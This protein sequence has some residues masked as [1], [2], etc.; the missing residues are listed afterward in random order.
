MAIL[1]RLK[2]AFTHLVCGYRRLAPPAVA[3]SHADLL[4]PISSPMANNEV[5][6]LSLMDIPEHLLTEIFLRLATIEDLAR[7]ST[8]CTEF[9]RLIT[10]RSFLRRVLGVHTPNFLPSLRRG[11]STQPNR[12]T[13]PRPPPTHSPAKPTSPSLSSHHPIVEPVIVPQE[14]AALVA[15]QDVVNNPWCEPFLGVPLIFG[16]DEDVGT[17][18]NVIWV[19]HYETECKTAVAAAFIFSSG[20]GKWKSV[21]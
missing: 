17:S 10:D 11:G 16:E 4:Y 15:H 19:A 7:I 20:T 12:P 21:G 2:A 1:N 14:L 9:R 18:F 13:P 8:T 6:G 3:S 5:V